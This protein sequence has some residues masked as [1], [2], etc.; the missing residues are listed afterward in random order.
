MSCRQVAERVWQCERPLKG[1]KQYLHLVLHV[2]GQLVGTAGHEGE[3][4]YGQMTAHRASAAETVQ[5]DSVVTR[6]QA[7]AQ[8]A[9]GRARRCYAVACPAFG[10]PDDPCIF[11]RHS[12]SQ[13]AD[14]CAAMVPM[15]ASVLRQLGKAVPPECQDP[16]VGGEH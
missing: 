10:Q 8:L 4:P 16:R 15:L 12:M 11:E 3:T 7:D 14:T 13:D 9:C 6:A 2:D 5:L 1:G